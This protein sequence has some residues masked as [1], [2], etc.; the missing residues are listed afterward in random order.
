MKSIFRRK[1]ELPCRQSAGGRLTKSVAIL[2][3]TVIWNDLS[4]A[5]IHRGWS[6]SEDDFGPSDGP[7]DEDWEE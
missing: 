7:D 5:A 6:I 2:I 1:F 4:T 3:L